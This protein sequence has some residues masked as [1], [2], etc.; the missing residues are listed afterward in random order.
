MAQQIVNTGTTNDDGTGDTVVLSFEKCNSNFTEL[1]DNPYTNSQVQVIRDQDDY[2]VQDATTITLEEGIYYEIIKPYTQTKQFVGGNAAIV[3]KPVGG[4]TAW[5]NYTG[6]APLFS[7]ANKRL[8]VE[9]L[10]FNAPSAELFAFSGNGA[11]DLNNILNVINCNIFNCLSIGTFTGVGGITMDLVQFASVTGST[12]MTFAGNG[13]IVT[14]IRRIFIGGLTAGSKGIDLGTLT[15]NGII[16]DSVI[17][18]GDSTAVPLSGLANTGNINVGGRLVVRESTFTGFTSPLSDVN[19][20]DI[21]AD[22]RENNGVPDTNDLGNIYLGSATTLT[23]ST[24][25]QWEEVDGVNWLGKTLDGFSVSASGVLTWDREY[26]IDIDVEGHCTVEKVGGGSDI[27]QVGVAKNWVAN[28]AP[29]ADSISETDS[30]SPS[31]APYGTTLTL[32]QGDN[33][34]LVARNQDSTSNLIFTVASIRAKS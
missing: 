7:M 34:R 8:W 33:L 27:I 28:N 18:S 24:I 19:Q 31:S 25:G 9:K 20:Q 10:F 26:D 16:L 21:R 5:L 3:G 11:F 13:N 23:I 15:T 6:T 1:Y 32:S 2:P 29:E 4:A 30:S 22:F 17:F 12:A 14:D